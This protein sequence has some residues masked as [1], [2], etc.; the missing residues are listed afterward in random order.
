[1]SSGSEWHKET[2]A[3]TLARL[4][5]LARAHVIATRPRICK[6]CGCLYQLPSLTNGQQCARCGI[7]EGT[8]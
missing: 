7:K 2:A 1:M 8:Q 3:H 5:R 4:L 6:Q